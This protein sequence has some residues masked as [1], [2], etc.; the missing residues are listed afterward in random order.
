MYDHLIEF[1]NKKKHNIK[2]YHENSTE[3]IEIRSLTSF[4]DDSGLFPK[5]SY[6]QRIWHIINNQLSLKI[7]ALTV[8]IQLNGTRG[9]KNI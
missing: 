8:I 1:Y 7:C 2:R 3:T 4:L 5:I 9:I 6:K